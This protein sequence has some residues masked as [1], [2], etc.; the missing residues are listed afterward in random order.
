M[1]LLVREARY[2]M[3]P[4]LPGRFQ[5]EGWRLGII[6]SSVGLFCIYRCGSS[7]YSYSNCNRIYYCPAV[8]QYR[9]PMLAYRAH[10]MLK[11]VTRYFLLGCI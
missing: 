3:F 11:T 7:L 2:I 10:P 8:G 4:K 9:G 6:G 1:E 5:I